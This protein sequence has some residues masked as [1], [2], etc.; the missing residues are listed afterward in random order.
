VTRAT[1]SIIGLTVVA[2]RA[3]NHRDVD[4]PCGRKLHRVAKVIVD[5]ASGSA[6]KDE[7]DLATA[8]GDTDTSGASVPAGGSL[9]TIPLEVVHTFTAGAAVTLACADLAGAGSQFALEAKI[10]AIPATTLIDTAL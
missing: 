2:A 9:E 3:Y 1:R 6:G 5:N 10:I 7:C 4:H 8:G